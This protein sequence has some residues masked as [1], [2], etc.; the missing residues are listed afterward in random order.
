MFKTQDVIG[1]V[2]FVAFNDKA[3]LNHVGLNIECG[4]FKIMGYDNFGLWVEH[5][6]LYIVNTE[7]ENGNSLPAGEEHRHAHVEHFFLLSQCPGG[8]QAQRKNLEADGC[9][10]RSCGT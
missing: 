3:M 9:R 6:N 5:P 8:R 2:I 1:D 10:R 4:H 7:D